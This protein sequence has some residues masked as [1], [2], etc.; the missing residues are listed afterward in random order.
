MFRTRSRRPWW[1]V[2]VGAV[3]IAAVA[4]ITTILV[5]PQDGLW[6]DA[7]LP[8]PPKVVP[9]T[10]E[11]GLSL[12]F[13]TDDEMRAAEVKL[14]SEP[15]VTGVITETRHQAA[16]RL[17][18]ALRDEVDF[19]G[20]PR[21]PLSSALH[22]TAADGVDPWLLG[23]DLR[24]KIG[25]A[26][27]V[28]TADCNNTEQEVC[29]RGV[30]AVVVFFKE[31]EHMAL[32]AVQLHDDIRLAG[33]ET[34]T[35]EQAY[36]DAR[37]RYRND[38]AVLKTITRAA[39][40]AYLFVYPVAGLDPDDLVVTLENELFLV[41]EVELTSCPRADRGTEPTR[42]IQVTCGKRITV[43]FDLDK[44]MLEA[45]DRARNDREIAEVATRLK[46]ENYRSA[47]RQFRG[48]PDVLDL[49]SV[50]QAPATLVATT[51]DGTDTEGLEYNG[52]SSTSTREVPA[53][54]LALPHPVADAEST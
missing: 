5:Q 34:V 49:L 47:T 31:D 42:L 13:D 18:T 9:A 30:V 29:A 27:D 23:D 28:E 43:Y 10:C 46:H 20:F 37:E 53:R 44:W 1:L 48:R 35:R 12:Y 54:C 17:H 6:W 45:A 2:G 16:E 22:L 41:D 15:R 25:A 52:W 51:A 3:A 4:G 14:R 36:R 39:A 8:H 24:K 40:P 38:P 21:G 32:A 7:R 19:R 11:T 33:V 50:D 26:D